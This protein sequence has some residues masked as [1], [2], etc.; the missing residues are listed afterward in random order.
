[1]KNKSEVAWAWARLRP[2]LEA[3]L[4]QRKKENERLKKFFSPVSDFDRWMICHLHFIWRIIR[5]NWFCIWCG[6]KHF[7]WTEHKCRQEY[8]KKNKEKLD[9]ED[10]VSETLI[11]C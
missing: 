5:W 7:S 11:N 9:G 3:Q 1:M 2:T 4:T 10:E 8:E 6:K